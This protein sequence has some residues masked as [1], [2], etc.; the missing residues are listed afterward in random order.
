MIKHLGEGLTPF[1]THGFSRV[2]EMPLIGENVLVVCRVDGGDAV[3]SLTLATSVQTKTLAGEPLGDRRYRFDLGM[4]EQPQKVNYRFFT[5]AQ[6]TPWFSFDVLTDQELSAPTALYQNGNVITACFD[7]EFIVI[8][9]GGE[10]MEIITE[11][12][13]AAGTLCECATLALPEG[14]TCEISKSEKIWELKRFSNV[15]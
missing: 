7:Q 5:D 12:G 15:V 8:F 4:F 13:V 10:T 14:F 9:L 6:E 11:K 3:P 1:E 2:P